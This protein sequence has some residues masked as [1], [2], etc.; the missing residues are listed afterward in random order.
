VTEA[1]PGR[2]APSF[3]CA[4]LLA[5][6][7]LACASTPGGGGTGSTGSTGGAGTGGATTGGTTSQGTG[8][9]SNCTTTNASTVVDVTIK[10][11]AFQP[12]CIVVGAG[13]PVTFTNQDD[14]AHTVT[15]FE[16]QPETFDS[17]AL[18]TGVA[19]THTFSSAGTHRSH[20]AI[21]PAIQ[22]SVL[23]Q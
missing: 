13:T 1:T 14:V 9:Y 21:H 20:C 6:L 4:L 18:G 2:H 7:A 8:D 5:T 19:F 11:F 23:V 17:G 22:M 10:D 16:D 12:S 15:A 3:A